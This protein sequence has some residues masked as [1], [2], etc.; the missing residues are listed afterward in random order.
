MSGRWS[1]VGILTEMMVLPESAAENPDNFYT[2]QIPPRQFRLGHFPSS[3][4]VK[5]SCKIIVV[6]IVVL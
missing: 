1:S 4:V 6:V 2:G 5:S 3:A